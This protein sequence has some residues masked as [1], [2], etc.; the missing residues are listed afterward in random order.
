MNSDS[1]WDEIWNDCAFDTAFDNFVSSSVYWVFSFIIQSSFIL[2]VSKRH[3]IICY[4]FIPLIYSITF[5]SKLQILHLTCL[6]YP[7]A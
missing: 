2:L 7:K 5:L 4:I 1:M 6:A 3:D